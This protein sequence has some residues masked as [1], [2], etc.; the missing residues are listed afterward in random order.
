LIKEN[1]QLF[2]TKDLKD[3][4]VYNLVAY[5]LEKNRQSLWLETV[6]ANE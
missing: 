6:N 2:L 5:H 4:A 3:D 1:G